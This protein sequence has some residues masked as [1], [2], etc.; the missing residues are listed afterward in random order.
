LCEHAG[1]QFGGDHEAVK[2]LTEYRYFFRTFVNDRVAGEERLEGANHKIGL[3]KIP[4]GDNCAY[5]KR[6]VKHLMDL[7]L[8]L[9]SH[10]GRKAF[11]G[12]IEIPAHAIERPAG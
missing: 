12:V 11:V 4:G 7:F 3:R 10:L 9:E 6:F 8:I 1:G 2:Q 5:A